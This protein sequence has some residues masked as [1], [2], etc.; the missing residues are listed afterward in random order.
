M[1]PVVLLCLLLPACDPVSAGAIAA[2][3][4]ASVPVFQ[5]SVP[6]LLVSG[7]TGRDCSVVRLD[8]GK[9]Y[10]RPVAPPPPRQLYC[11]RSLGVV[12]CW[13]NPEDLPDHPP[14]VADGPA[15]LTRAQE[16]DRTKRWPGL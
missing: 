5:R 12:D 13:N 4:V 11:T 16:A 3:N 7:V 14:Q 8:Q 9:S 15:T 2:A 10:C 6:D 1:R